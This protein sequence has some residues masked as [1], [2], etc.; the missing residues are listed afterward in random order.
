MSITID[1]I[2]AA[3][4]EEA[5][6]ELLA[7]ELQVLLPIEA[8][9]NRDQ[10]HQILASLPRGLRA[11]AGT[12]EFDVSMTQEDLAM[13]I[14]CQHEARDLHETIS[15]LRELELAQIADL[16]EQAM[17]IMEPHLDEMRKQQVSVENLQ[18]WLDDVGVQD[19]IDPMN[20]I[21]WD[22]SAEAGPLGMHRSWVLY[23]RK[24][25]ERCVVAEA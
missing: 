22:F 17:K 18:K 11:M 16:L 19:Q 20:D 3:E 7:T 25:P 4:S 8:Q 9:K 21:I 15:G 14:A 23:A 5:L 12:H 10:F 1:T 2:R 24:Y 13:H 6:I